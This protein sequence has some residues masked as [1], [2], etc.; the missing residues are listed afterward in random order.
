MSLFH[1][2]AALG[3]SACILCRSWD[4]QIPID[5]TQGKGPP[6]L[7][8]R[9]CI[10]PRGEYLWLSDQEWVDVEDSS[11]EEEIKTT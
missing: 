7:T 4:R 3:E 5:L 2:S 11:V 6:S 1:I 10:C 8:H 9:L